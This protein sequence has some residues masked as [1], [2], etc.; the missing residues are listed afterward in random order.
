MNSHAGPA[1]APAPA[2][3]RFART[4]GL[5]VAGGVLLTVLLAAGLVRRP[6]PALGLLLLVAA[7]AIVALARPRLSRLRVS[8]VLVAGLIVLPAAALLGP[9]FALPAAPQ[10]FL[11]RLVLAGIIVLGVTYLIVRRKPLPYAAQDVT[12]PVVLWFLW[13]LVGVAWSADKA[14]AFN[15]LAI[16]F[17]MMALLLATA[18]CGANRKSLLWLGYLLVLGYLFVAGF[19]ML[20]ARFGVRLPT[21]RLI[22]AVTSQTYA[23]TSVFVNQNDLATYLAFCWPFMLCAFFFTR[24]ARW[25]LLDVLLILLGAAAF[26]RT[27]S[28]SSLVAAGISTLAAVVLFWHLKA[29]LSARTGKVLGA[30]VAVLI[31]VAGG[32]LLFNN[33]SSDMLRQFRLESLL[34]QAQAGKGSGEIRTSLTNRGLQI[35]GAT[36]L[37]GAGPGQA[38]TIISSGTTALGISNLHDW[39]LET[40]ADGGIVGFALHLM[41]FLLLVIT[42]WPIA[43][44][45]PDPLTRYLASGAVLALLGWTVGAVGPSSSVSFAPLWILYG[46]GLAVVSRSRLAASERRTTGAPLPAGLPATAGATAVTD[47]PATVAHTHGGAS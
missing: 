28:R 36:F 31:V 16:V 1:A 3:T 44:G 32:Y 6:L 35:A 8:S 42:L 11:F 2:K 26:V 37:A 9:S 27:G 41:F 15:Y 33:S 34:S 12:L 4:D 23:V 46:L 30:A 40:Y 7:V 22:T 18:A 24:K 21:S 20:E 38:E 45:D 10:L 43:R 25:L 14:A 47:A 29:R 19:S 17:T 39:W 13:L 5:V